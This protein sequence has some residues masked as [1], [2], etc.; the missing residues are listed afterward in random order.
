MRAD[1]GEIARANVYLTT[2]TWRAADGNLPMGQSDLVVF[3]RVSF[4][5]AVSPFGLLS[6]LV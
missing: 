2:V 3:V 6:G 4:I 1:P 5:S